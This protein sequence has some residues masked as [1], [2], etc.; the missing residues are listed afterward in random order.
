MKAVVSNNPDVAR[1]I[2]IHG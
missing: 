2:C 1:M